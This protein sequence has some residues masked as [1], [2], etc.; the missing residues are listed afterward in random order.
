MVLQD[1]PAKAA[2]EAGVKQ[3]Y[4]TPFL[5]ETEVATL[6]AKVQKV[7]PAVEAIETEQ[8]FN[9]Q[10][11]APLSEEQASVLEWC[12]LCTLC[13]TRPDASCAWSMP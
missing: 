13:G 9:V 4:R 1:A 7:L 12:V 11:D 3:Y 6:L 8:C 2:V 5:G 10:V